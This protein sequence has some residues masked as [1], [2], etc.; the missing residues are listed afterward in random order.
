MW[1]ALWPRWCWPILS[2]RTFAVAMPIALVVGSLLL[3]VNQGSQLASGRVGW[4]TL[5]RAVAN[6]AIPYVVS[7]LGY[8]RAGQR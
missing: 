2:G 6:Y 5:L 4:S 8:L 3:A 7:S 1:R